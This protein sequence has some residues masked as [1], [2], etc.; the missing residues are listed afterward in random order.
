MFRHALDVTL[1]EPPHGGFAEVRLCEA[2]ILGP[3]EHE[4]DL[5]EELC[6]R[7][8]RINEA[9]NAAP[10]SQDSITRG[11]SNLQLTG[12]PA[13]QTTLPVP[14]PPSMPVS[15]RVTQ[16]RTRQQQ[17]YLRCAPCG[18]DPEVYKGTSD[19]DLTLQMV[20]KHGGQQLM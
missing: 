6:A 3:A 8:T 4:R 11:L 13:T 7:R 18:T 14:A 16:P 17:E 15:R 9:G 1:E 10:G 5:V 20:H 19:H 12:T 2:Q